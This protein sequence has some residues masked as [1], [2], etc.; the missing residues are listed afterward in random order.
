MDED[1]LHLWRHCTNL[2]GL[3]LKET[4]ITD[5]LLAAMIESMTASS[6]SR[7]PLIHL[8]VADTDIS[9]N[10]LESVIRVSRDTLTSLAVCSNHF[11]GIDCEILHALVEGSRKVRVQ[12]GQSDLGQA[13]SELKLE[14]QAI[15]G[16]TKRT[17]TTNTVLTSI[18][19]SGLS[20]GFF[21]DD[22]EK[23]FQYATELNTI[24]L[25]SC[26]VHDGAL[27]VLAEN[28]RKR[29]ERQGLGVPK[30]WY[31]HEKSM[32]K[33]QGKD[34][35][36][37]TP[38]PKFYT[39]GK[40]VGGLK[41]LW[42][43]DCSGIGNF[44]VRAIVRSCVGLERLCLSGDSRVSLRIF[45][46]P[47]A[48]LDLVEL[49]ISEVNVGFRDPGG[50]M[51]MYEEVGEDEYAEARRFPIAPVKDFNTR[52]DFD[53]DGNYDYISK[54]SSEDDDDNHWRNEDEWELDGKDEDINDDYGIDDDHD[55][56]G[57]SDATG[58][59][60]DDGKPMNF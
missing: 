21:E 32:K 5:I 41:V 19:L 20:G 43:K 36:L 30:A 17:F 14:G 59:Y 60:G 23:L 18:S 47:W 46:G 1:M 54:P 53:S 4:E 44:G 28:Y 51:E 25:E 56:D 57:D 7:L 15:C 58:I 40:V 13:M 16:P 8:N 24:R 31:K 3:S 49:D 27:L 33:R 37:H 9:D 39:G 12:G 42:L 2:R 52:L 10:C 35:S 50:M 34:K 11:Y 48:C 6:G 22:F 55:H 45:R 38:R 29:M 26:E